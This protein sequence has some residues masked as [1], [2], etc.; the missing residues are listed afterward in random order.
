MSR[1][2]TTSEPAVPEAITN[3]SKVPTLTAAHFA[4]LSQRVDSIEG[5]NLANA[6][7]GDKLQF[8]DTPPVRGTSG[9][10]VRLT[11]AVVTEGLSARGDLS[12]LAIIVPLPVAVAP[13]GLTAEAKAEGVTLKWTA[14]DAAATREGPPVIVGYNVFRD[15][16]E[17]NK[18]V[19]P[20]PIEKTTFTDTPP[21]GS[22]T[23][24]VTAVASAGP[25]VIQ[26]DPSPQASVDFKD[27]V[28][29]PTPAN[30]T[31]LL[32]TR[33]VRL[34]WDASPA[35]DLRGY[36]VYRWQGTIKLKLTVGPT[37]NTFF[38]DESLEQGQTYT[39]S[40]T[41]VDNS[42]NESAPVSSQPIVLPKAP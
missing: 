7:V 17:L 4:K 18:P 27:L 11:Y 6:T 39:Y 16:D 32:E 34:I 2:T 19:N 35:P 22:H 30:L 13:A 31:T 24:R 37:P 23:Y 25:P 14:P 10:P 40:V 26:S 42:G 36:H 33:V 20:T 29:P 5:A 21:Y 1:D 9:R 38:G 28:P 41:A 12:N 8:D 15:T 3:F